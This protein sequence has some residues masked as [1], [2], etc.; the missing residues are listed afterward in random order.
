LAKLES[1]NQRRREIADLYTA[2]LAGIPG[3]TLPYV[4]PDV[5]H[6]FHVYCVLVGQE[7]PL[8]KEDFMWELY[9]K[10]R[11]KVWSHYMPM[12]LT[13]AYRNLGHREGECPRVEALF[14][15]YVSLPIHPR[16]TSEGIQYLIDSIRALV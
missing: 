10:N 6:V 2:G 13:T 12:H 7:F 3:L 1:F 15:Q 16:L 5:H 14:H 9:T 11:I 8:S 4:A